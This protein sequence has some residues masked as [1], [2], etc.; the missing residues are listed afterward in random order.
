MTGRVISSSTTGAA[1]S[2][3]PRE[4]IERVNKGYIAGHDIVAP[5]EDV[6]PV[7]VYLGSLGI[8][9]FALSGHAQAPLNDWFAKHNCMCISRMCRATGRDKMTHLAA[10]CANLGVVPSAGCYLGDW[11]QDMRAATCRQHDTNWRDS[12]AQEP[13]SA[14]AQRRPYT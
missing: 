4:E 11:G 3:P 14:E 10:L 1:A 5:F 9:M 2:P 7:L 12:L 13:R 6:V 8:P